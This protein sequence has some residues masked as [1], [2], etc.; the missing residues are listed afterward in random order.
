MG[1]GER[2]RASTSI[3]LSPTERALLERGAALA[4]RSWQDFLRHTAL[5]EARRLI[6]D[7]SQKKLRPPTA[8]PGFGQR[9]RTAEDA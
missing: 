1:K 3:R 8:S 5:T 9:L 2:V 7:E 6:T 4:G